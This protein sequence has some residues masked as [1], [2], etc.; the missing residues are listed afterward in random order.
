MWCDAG[1]RRDEYSLNM[2]WA[3]VELRSTHIPSQGSCVT[4]GESLSMGLVHISA[5]ITRYLLSLSRALG[6]KESIFKADIDIVKS[7]EAKS[8]EN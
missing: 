8:S 6:W 1:D 7:I 4:T 2:S 5:Q 3:V